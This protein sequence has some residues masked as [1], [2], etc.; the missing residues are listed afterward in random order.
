MIKTKPPA[1]LAN[2]P[3]HEKSYRTELALVD[4]FASIAGDVG[5]A[6]SC[7]AL[8][9]EFDF[10][11][12]RTDLVGMDGNDLLHAFEAKLT[13][14]KVALDQARR[15]NSFAHFAYVV[16][17][18]ENAR[19]AIRS[20]HEFK[21]RGV[22]LIVVDKKTA[23]LEIEPKRIEPLLPWLTSKAHSRLGHVAYTSTGSNCKS[24]SE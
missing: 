5:S 15:N 11:S 8:I 14:W 6:F 10:I 2:R 23:R 20:Q 22:G 3:K 4:D 13:K 16:L 19:A 18:K 17:P 7:S 24:S 21:R 9:R 1:R 12:G